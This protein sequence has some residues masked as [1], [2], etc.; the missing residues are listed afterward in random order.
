MSADFCCMRT[1]TQRLSLSL[2]DVRTELVIQYIEPNSIP[3]SSQ[4]SITYNRAHPHLLSLSIGF[5]LNPRSSTA[6]LK[7]TFH[8][9][10]PP[11]IYRQ[12][13][14]CSSLTKRDWLWRWLQRYFLE[15]WLY[16]MRVFSY[17]AYSKSRRKK[18]VVFD[19]FHP[20]SFRLAR[21]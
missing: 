8:A 9:R 10:T 17:K 1:A 2:L 16:L 20:P 7:R 14:L 15:S 13:R 19:P 18:H 11:L 5:E 3:N 6:D 21:L 12:L 4:H